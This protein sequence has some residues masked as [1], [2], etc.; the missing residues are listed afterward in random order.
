MIIIAPTWAGRVDRSGYDNFRVA[1]AGREG[2][3][4]NFLVD[5]DRQSGQGVGRRQFS[6]RHELGEGESMNF[7]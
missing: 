5:V 1:S 3:D 2:I 6:R 4:E 7:H